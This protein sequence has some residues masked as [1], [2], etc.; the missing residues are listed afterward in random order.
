MGTEKKGRTELL[1]GLFLFMG[2]AILGAL[3]ITFGRLG[4]GLASPYE[5]TV[6]FPNANGLTTGADVLLSGAKIGFV[7]AQPQLVGDSYRV[8]VR[9]KVQGDV[10]IPRKSKFMV[11]S[12]SLLGD[13]FVDVLPLSEID[14]GDFW[15]P[16]E[17]IEGARASGF[18]ELAVRGSAV[19]D[20]LTVSLKHIQTLTANLNQNLL[21]DTS[22]QNLQQTFEN[23]RETTAAF[24]KASQSVDG[25]VARADRVLHAAE[26]TV[27]TLDSAGKEIQKFSKNATEGKGALSVLVNDRETGDNLRALISNMRR[28]GVLFYK[29]R[30]LPAGES[31]D[32]EKEKKEKSR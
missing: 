21:N 24:K 2:L 3:V 5:L 19:M 8:A 11:G 18:E 30:P 25:V 29:D 31:R 7:S 6:L 1:V 13:K 23:L 26:G 16:G 10:H 9:V 28:S 20:E 22:I 32:S 4:Q 15:Q 14:A 17:I 27:K 12:S